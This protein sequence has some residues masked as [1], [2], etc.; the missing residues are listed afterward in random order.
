[1]EDYEDFYSR[2]VYRANA[3][4]SV[5]AERSRRGTLSS[6]HFHGRPVLQP[7]LSPQQRTE[8]AKQRQRAVERE[9]ERIRA[10]DNH[11]KVRDTDRPE[12]EQG[13]EASCLDLSFSRTH[14]K[15]QPKD[16]SITGFNS[17]S[18]NIRERRRETL[19]VLNSRMEKVGKGGDES[20][21][22]M[23]SE[24]SEISERHTQLEEE[25]EETLSDKENQNC[26]PDSGNSSTSVEI[27]DPKSPGSALTS[28]SFSSSLLGSYSQLPSPQPSFSS[29]VHCLKK[30][31][32]TGNILISLPV[33]ESEL[34]PQGVNETDN[35][36][37]ELHPS[38]NGSS[39][40]TNS[41]ELS[42]LS[43][44]Q[45]PSS[46][47]DWNSSCSELSTSTPNVTLR[48][49]TQPGPV[50]HRQKDSA[51]YSRSSSALLNQSYDVLNPSPSLLR[52]QISSCPETLSVAIQLRG[53]LPQRPLEYSKTP[54]CLYDTWA[55]QVLQDKAAGEVQQQMQV[56]ETLCQRLEEKH[57]HQLDNKT[58][59]PQQ[60][61]SVDLQKAVCS[62]TATV[63]GFL[64][65]RLL[66]TEKIKHLRKTIRDSREVIR[67]FQADTQQR[68]ASF[69]LQDLS[70]QHRV[71][72][73]L[74]AALCNVHEIFFVWP[75]R[76][77]LALLQQDRELCT[78]RRLRDTEKAKC[79]QVSS[80]LSSA[81]QKSLDRKK[82]RVLQP[83]QRQNALI[84]SQKLKPVLCVWTEGGNRSTRRKPTQTQ[85]FSECDHYLLSSRC[86]SM[87]TKL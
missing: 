19:R 8:M 24:I 37:S 16:Q 61:S 74:R 23:I 50:P 26:D 40:A 13:A 73:Q 78:E 75:V 69:T 30:W 49:H 55:N 7:M 56:L 71:R 28:H 53:G 44:P 81:T 15:K 79:S 35:V 45:T 36:Q 33:S 25:G 85:G 3:E 31:S 82:Q 64:T 32:T 38:G 52:P 22:E 6:I 46:G 87:Y 62:V 17:S 67:S 12:A 5:S 72:A 51:P 20:E 63:R 84:I 86:F 77:R 68:R 1:M 2:C 43:A 9:R 66:Q 4:A 48:R 59:R 34:S 42:V 14:T 21:E 54:E 65:R 47:G 58:M 70:L 60:V 57:A 29:P 76:N 27:F 39:A 10:Q 80:S 83:A 18:N 41:L 11:I